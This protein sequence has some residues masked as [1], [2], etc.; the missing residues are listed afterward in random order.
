MNVQNYHKLMLQL[1]KTSVKFEK[2][3]MYSQK[4]S[5]DQGILAQKV[6]AA[7][8]KKSCTWISQAFMDV[9]TGAIML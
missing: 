1:N 3:R 4:K 2:L 5:T 8:N 9:Q 6:S 7:F